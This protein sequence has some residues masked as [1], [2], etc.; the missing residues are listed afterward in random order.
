MNCMIKYFI[1]IITVSAA[2]FAFDT[3]NELP[4]IPDG[5]EFESENSIVSSEIESISPNYE[6]SSYLQYES[7]ITSSYSSDE[8][9]RVPQYNDN[10]DSMLTQSQ[11]VSSV[12]VSSESESKQTLSAYNKN[13]DKITKIKVNDGYYVTIDEN[14][15]LVLEDDLNNTVIIDDNTNYHFENYSNSKI[16]VNQNNEQV[17]IDYNGNITYSDTNGKRITKNIDTILI[18]QSSDYSNTKD[19]TAQ[20]YD[21]KVHNVFEDNTPDSVSNQV[22]D[23]K[24]STANPYLLIIVFFVFISGVAIIIAKKN[25]K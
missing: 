6:V 16:I 18:E 9:T 2:I 24:H 25:K 13:R 8:E 21:N 23:S 19:T 14:Y 17:E 22:D 11:D 15:N 10:N 4:F 1:N 20:N 7:R 12:S 5:D 3:V